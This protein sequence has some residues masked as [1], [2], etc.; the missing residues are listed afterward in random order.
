MQTTTGLR[1][2]SRPTGPTSE[3]W[4]VGCSSNA[5]GPTR[6]GPA[7]PMSHSPPALQP[8]SRRRP[9]DQ[10]EP[11]RSVSWL[12]SAGFPAYGRGLVAPAR[13]GRLSSQS[14]RGSRAVSARTTSF[15]PY[16][17]GAAEPRGR[18]PTRSRRRPRVGPKREDANEG[19]QVSAAEPIPRAANRLHDIAAELLA[20]I[21]H[22][23]L[24]HVG[25][26]TAVVSPDL[27]EELGL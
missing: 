4:P 2:V 11:A 19:I 1:I 17:H 9:V 5:N 3:R 27:I 21:A 15:L 10:P 8:R 24:H 13:E 16:S 6:H 12:D 25:G 23:D 20:K 22:V 7:R 18:Q 26:R 14:P